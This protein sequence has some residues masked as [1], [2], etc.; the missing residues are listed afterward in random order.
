M[1]PCL[2][3]LMMFVLFYFSF[4]NFFFFVLKHFSFKD[5]TDDQV[6]MCCVLLKTLGSLQT[7]V[8]LFVYL[9]LM[10]SAE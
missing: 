9:F 7:I 8:I 4:F 6:E 1:L 2:C 5:V 3:A 10:Y